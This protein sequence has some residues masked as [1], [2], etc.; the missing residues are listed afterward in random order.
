MKKTVNVVRF[1]GKKNMNNSR[2]SKS[3]YFLRKILIDVL[4]QLI[5]I[6]I[7][8]KYFTVEL[9]EEEEISKRVYTLLFKVLKKKER[10]LQ[11]KEESENYAVN[12]F[13]TPR[14]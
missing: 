6:L 13:T 9:Q 2:N 10:L 4:L 5:Q 1:K 7:D 14:E 11:T 12:W 3:K 8:N